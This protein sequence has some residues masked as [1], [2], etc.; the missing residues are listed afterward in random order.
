MA[1]IAIKLIADIIQETYNSWLKKCCHKRYK[2]NTLKG[3]FS[4]IILQFFQHFYLIST[5]FPHYFNAYI[6]IHNTFHLLFQTPSLALRYPPNLFI[7]KISRNE[8][9][10]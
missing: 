5:M 4:A 6:F 10:S 9:K 3:N 1:T 7:K 8:N 2:V